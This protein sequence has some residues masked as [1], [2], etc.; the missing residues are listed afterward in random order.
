MEKL[1]LLEVHINGDSKLGS[2]L[3]DEM[4]GDTDEGTPTA[5]DGGLLS[6]AFGGSNGSDESTDDDIGTAEEAE[7]STRDGDSVED[8]DSIDDSVKSLDDISARKG[9]TDEEESTAKPLFL[10]G[11]LVAI[12]GVLVVAKRALGSEG[13]TDEFEPEMVELEDPTE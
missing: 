10:I 9:K 5:T 11:G 6:F 4:A 3:G 2:Y 7:S 1:T 12:L 13:E 8:D